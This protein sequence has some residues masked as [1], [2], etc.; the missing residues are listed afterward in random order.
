MVKSKLLLNFLGDYIVWEVELLW[1][2]LFLLDIFKI[3][4]MIM[5]KFGMKVVFLKFQELVKLKSRIV[6]FGEFEVNQV[7]YLFLIKNV[8]QEVI[9]VFEF[10]VL[11]YFWFVNVYDSLVEVYLKFGDK[12]MVVRY[13]E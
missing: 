12:V 6:Y 11:Q 4:K 9:Q 1:I 13:Y 10:N 2:L 5:G 3:I 8:Y 7:G